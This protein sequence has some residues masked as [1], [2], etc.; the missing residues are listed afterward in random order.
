M[1]PPSP[2]PTL[3]QELI[4]VP[5][6][7]RRIVA[8]TEPRHLRR[9]EHALDSPAEAASRLRYACPERLQN[10]EDLVGI[11]FLDDRLSNRRRIDGEGHLP[12]RDVF[13]IAP[14]RT[15][16]FDI[17]VSEGA[18]CHPPIELLALLLRIQPI[19]DHR[20][21]FGGLLARL[22]EREPPSA[23]ESDLTAAAASG[24][25]KGPAAAAVG[26]NEVKATPIGVLAGLLDRSRLGGRKAVQRTA[27]HSRGLLS[28][29]CIRHRSGC[30]RTR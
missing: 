14:G 10:L 17:V 22:G 26:D 23:P 28:R 18:E 27:T 15:H 24:V 20:A 3:R 30:V 2:F 16:G 8:I 29:T 21:I 1:V 11:D 9:V 7:S 12:L 13:R 4:Q 5:A 6:P 19:G 25:A